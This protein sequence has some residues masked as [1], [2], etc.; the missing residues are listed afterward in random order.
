[1]RQKWVEP[2]SVQGVM[3]K[4]TTAEICCKWNSSKQTE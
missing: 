4:E 3:M 1:M 2:K